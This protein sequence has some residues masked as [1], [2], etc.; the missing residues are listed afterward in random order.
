MPSS[1]HSLPLTA[2]A[3]GS[4]A[5]LSRP[6]VAGLDARAM[7]SEHPPPSPAR[8]HGTDHR[9]IVHPFRPI[10]APGRFSARFLIQV[11]LSSP[12]GIYWECRG[13]FGRHEV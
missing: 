6:A 13:D 10:A 11:L 8:T 2:P 12:F 7:Q 3:L 5:R 4:V 9:P 1:C